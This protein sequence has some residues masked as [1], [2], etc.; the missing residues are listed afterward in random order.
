MDFLAVTHGAA[1]AV[2]AQQQG[3]KFTLF[4]LA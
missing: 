2:D 1:G 3:G 4:D